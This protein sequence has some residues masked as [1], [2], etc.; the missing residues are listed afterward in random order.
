MPADELNIQLKYLDIFLTERKQKKHQ[1]KC[2]SND[3][4]NKTTNKK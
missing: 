3:L 2:K 4:E 1:K